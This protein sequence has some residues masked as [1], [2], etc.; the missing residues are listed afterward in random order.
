MTQLD[1]AANIALFITRELFTRG[2]SPDAT[3]SAPQGNLCR[4]DD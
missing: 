2:H 3:V 4:G 1:K